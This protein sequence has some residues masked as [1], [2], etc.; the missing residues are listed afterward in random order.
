MQPDRLAICATNLDLYRQLASAGWDDAQLRQL[1]DV[2]EVV[3]RFS[4]GSFRPNW[5]PFLCHL[6][7]VASIVSWDSRDPVL[8]A[9]ALAHSA[10]E[11]GRYPLSVRLS[12]RR[13]ERFLTREL[14]AEVFSLVKAYHGADWKRLMAPDPAAGRTA[15]ETALQHMKLADMLDDL[16]DELSPVATGKRIGVARADMDGIATCIAISRAIG[17]PH[18]ASAYGA[19]AATAPVRTA[20]HEKRGR[21]FRLQSGGR[22]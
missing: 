13:I 18:L 7:G 9:A 2:Y 16:A 10:F 6:V 17:A 12:G 15:T 4:F 5:K 1:R 11:F 21:T 19:L 22:R 3:A 8:V 20:I 14:G